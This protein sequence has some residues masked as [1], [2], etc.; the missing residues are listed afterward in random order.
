VACSTL[1]CHLIPD[2]CCVHQGPRTPQPGPSML[3][4]A[5]VCHQDL[6]PPH[7]F[8]PRSIS[9]LPLVSGL[10][11]HFMTLQFCLQTQLRGSSLGSPSHPQT[12]PAFR[13]HPTSAEAA[14]AC[15]HSET[16]PACTHMHTFI[17]ICTHHTPHMFSHTCTHSYTYVHTHTYHTRSH[18][19]APTYIYNTCSH[20][21]IH[22]HICTHTHYMCSH[23]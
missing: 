10:T 16:T 17:Y 15:I 1:T 9:C 21:L 23:I 7:C 13:S 4:W 3:M 5:T 11:F 20:T 2:T 14:G 18:T 6:H 8:L 12:P 19:H 22:P